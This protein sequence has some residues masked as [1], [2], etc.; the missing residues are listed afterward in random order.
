M[1]FQSARYR[2]VRQGSGCSSLGAGR[3]QPLASYSPGLGES[4]PP[5]SS[6][7]F[8]PVVII[9][10]P[11]GSRYLQSFI[12]TAIIASLVGVTIRTGLQS[13]GYSDT[14]GWGCECVG[15]GVVAV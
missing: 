7:S 13:N 9:T 4:A 3:G 2:R 14:Q 12:P 6:Q 8:I 15:V 1:F 5:G 11:A 10:S